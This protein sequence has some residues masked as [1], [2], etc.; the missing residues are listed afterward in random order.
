MNASRTARCTSY[1]HVQRRTYCSLSWCRRCTRL[2]AVYTVHSTVLN[3]ELASTTFIRREIIEPWRDAGRDRQST[4]IYTAAACCNAT[5][6]HWRGKIRCVPTL[7]ANGHGRPALL[8]P[9]SCSQ[10]QKISFVSRGSPL[11]YGDMHMRRASFCPARPAVPDAAAAL[12]IHCAGTARGHVA[13]CPAPS[14]NLVMDRAAL[15]S[16]GDRSAES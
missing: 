10:R 12:R 4:V 13:L 11:G 15:D 1:P 16:A 14:G 2:L 8:P 6:T 7:L 3:C 5:L 9:H